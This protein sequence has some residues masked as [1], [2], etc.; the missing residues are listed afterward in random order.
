MQ[1]NLAIM[2]MCAA[3]IQILLYLLVYFPFFLIWFVFCFKG[4][5]VEKVYKRL[6]LYMPLFSSFFYLI[7]WVCLL[8][9]NGCWLKELRETLS[10]VSY[11][12]LSV[13]WQLLKM[14]WTNGEYLQTMRVHIK[15]AAIIPLSVPVHRA[16]FYVFQAHP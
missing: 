3:L 6:C 9:V 12:S 7:T 8:I 5:W 14:L 11:Y 16:A 2:I 4:Q 15:T 10:G 1:K 13:N